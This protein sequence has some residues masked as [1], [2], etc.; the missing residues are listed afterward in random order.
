M[1]E[2]LPARAGA[3]QGRLGSMCR[4]AAGN[5]KNQSTEIDYSADGAASTVRTTVAETL[6]QGNGPFRNQRR[7]GP[8]ATLIL[9][10]LFRARAAFYGSERSARLIAV[11]H[12]A[13]RHH[14]FQT[15]GVH[16][17]HH[18]KQ[19]PAIHK[20]QGRRQWLVRMQHRHGL[21]WQQRGQR[22]VG[23]AGFQ[24]ARAQRA[25]TIV[26]LNQQGVK[27]IFAQRGAGFGQRRVR[28]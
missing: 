21:G 5:R 6:Q 23:C 25:P 13:Q 26:C 19:R 20:V 11:Q 1:H 24:I 16:A 15:G 28:C 22:G 18:G 27:A 8:H 14:A 7:F 17:A 3:G 12:R 2:V 4:Y 10:Y 9:K